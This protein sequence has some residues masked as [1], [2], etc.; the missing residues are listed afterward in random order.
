[1]RTAVC[2]VGAFVPGPVAGGRERACRVARKLRVVAH[3]AREVQVMVEWPGAGA[4]AGA[5]GEPPK[6][7]AAAVSAQRIRVSAVSGCSA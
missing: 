4:W 5:A 6:A 1:M 2:V 3:A 7:L